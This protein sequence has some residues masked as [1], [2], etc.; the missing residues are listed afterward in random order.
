[1]K[2]EQ[3]LQRLSSL[4]N[5]AKEIRKIIEAHEIPAITK[6]ERF[7]NIVKCLTQKTDKEKYPDSVFYFDGDKFM[8]EIKKP[9]I[10][11]S[12]PNVWSVF[13]IEYSMNYD[14][15]QLFIKQQIEKHFKREG[16]TPQFTA[17]QE[18]K[19][20]GNCDNSIHKTTTSTQ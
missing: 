9:Y 5:E 18:L 8:F 19:Q 4:E 16:L 11:C 13:E 10:W 1:M 6:E 3:A 7:Y 17:S 12:Y 20:K 15:T 2:K 14:D